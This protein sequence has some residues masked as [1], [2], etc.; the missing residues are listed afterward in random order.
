VAQLLECEMIAK[1]FHQFRPG[2]RFIDDPA[3]S[4]IAGAN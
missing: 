4:D 1:G 3:P 2:L